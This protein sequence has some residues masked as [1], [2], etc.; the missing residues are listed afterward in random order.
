MPLTPLDISPFFD[1][2]DSTKNYVQVLF[3]PGYPIQSRELTT[4]QS[5]IKDQIEKFGNNIY[6]DGSNIL[7]GGINVG[8]VDVLY[9]SSYT[10]NPPISNT[11]LDES[12]NKI[13]KEIGS[14]NIDQIKKMEGCTVTGLDTGIKAKILKVI[15]TGDVKYPVQLVVTYLKSGKINSAMADREPDMKTTGVNIGDK[16][17]TEGSEVHEFLFGEQIIARFEENYTLISRDY[18]VHFS[19]MAKGA[20]A[21]SSPGVYYFS[22]NFIS[23]GLQSILLAVSTA[24]YPDP[25]ITDPV[26]NYKIGFSLSNRIVTAAEDPSLYD[27]AEGYSSFGTAGASRLQAV[28]TLDKRPILSGTNPDEV[29]EDQNF[30]E[31]VRIVN[32]E[33]LM[34]ISDETQ[35]SRLTETLARR[36][37]DESGD[38][39][40]NPFHIETIDNPDDPSSFDID[41]G[42]SKA[43][44][45][46]FEIE[47]TGKTTLSISKPRDKAAIEKIK[48]LAIDIEVG[49]TIFIDDAY[50]TDSYDY[51]PDRTLLLSFESTTEITSGNLTA[52]ES[53]IIENAGTGT[54]FVS[55]GSPT[56]L[57]GAYFIANQTGAPTWG[58][59]TLKVRNK[60]VGYARVATVGDSSTS[61]KNYIGLSEVTPFYKIIM[62]VDPSLQFGQG[63]CISL[64]NPTSLA[65]SGYGYF[66]YSEPCYSSGSTDHF[67]YLT[68]VTGFL[69]PEYSVSTVNNALLGNQKRDSFFEVGSSLSVM[70]VSTF[71]RLE[72]LEGS[73]S[74]ELMYLAAG[75]SFSGKASDMIYPVG[76]TVKTVLPQDYS[77]AYSVLEKDNSGLFVPVTKS[78]TAP[79][80][81]EFKTSVLTF[82]TYGEAIGGER[83]YVLSLG[84]AGIV[85]SGAGIDLIIHISRSNVGKYTITSVENGGSGFVA[86]DSITISGDSIGGTSP[87]NDIVI[88]LLNPGFSIVDNGAITI[89][90]INDPLQVLV[91]GGIVYQV[92]QT[93]GTSA[94]DITIK[95]GTAPASRAIMGL[96]F[97]VRK[98]HNGEYALESSTTNIDGIGG[99]ISDDGSSP[100]DYVYYDAIDPSDIIL[101]NTTGT[102]TVKPEINVKLYYD[103][104]YELEFVSSGNYDLSN[105][106]NTISSGPLVTGLAYQIVNYV[107]G[108]N[109]SNVGGPAASSVSGTH[110][111]KWFVASGTTPTTWTTSDLLD[112][113]EQSQIKIKGSAFA[114][115]G[116]LDGPHYGSVGSRGNDIVITVNGNASPT[117]TNV[118]LSQDILDNAILF[119][120][121]TYINGDTITIP[122]ILIGGTTGKNDVVIKL[123]VPGSTSPYYD[124]NFLNYF[125]GTGAEYLTNTDLLPE[126]HRVA[127]TTH[128]LETLAITPGPLAYAYGFRADDR[129]IALEVGLLKVLTVLQSITPRMPPTGSK[130]YLKTGSDTSFKVGHKIIGRDSGA[131]AWVYRANS[132]VGL[133]SNKYLYGY[134]Q[135][136]FNGTNGMLWA[137]STSSL[138]IVEIVNKVGDFIRGEVIYQKVYDQETDPTGSI[139]VILERIVS[140]DVDPFYVPTNCVD[141]TNRFIIDTGSRKTISDIG[142]I[143]YRN[144]TTTLAAGKIG[145]LLSYYETTT[146]GDFSAADSY[147]LF[148]VVK[149]VLTEA[150]SDVSGSFSATAETLLPDL[151]NYIDFR[152]I[153]SFINTK[154]R[155]AILTA[156]TAQ[157]YNP[158]SFSTRPLYETTGLPIDE[159]FLY[160]DLE[161]YNGR[162]DKIFLSKKGN[163]VVAKGAPSK[164]PQPAK[165]VDDAMLLYE[166]RIPPYC[167]SVSEI[168]VIANDNRRYTMRD[169]GNIER[170]LNSLQEQVTLNTLEIIALN[171]FIGGTDNPN[172]NRLKIGFLVNG[173][174]DDLKTDITNSENTCVIDINEQRLEPAQIHNSINLKEIVGG[175]GYVVNNGLVT[176]PYTEVNYITQDK[177]SRSIMINNSNASSWIGDLVLSPSRD[178][179]KASGSTATRLLEVDE[180]N[181]NTFNTVN[182]PSSRS[183]WSAPLLT[184][185][186][187]PL[188]NWIGLDKKWGSNV[189]TR[190]NLRTNSVKNEGQTS[191]I[192]SEDKMRG[193]T[194][195]FSGFGLKANVKLS[196]KFNGIDV[197]NYCR[198]FLYNDIEGSLGPVG[199]LYSDDAGQ[200]NGKFALPD[201]T[202]EAGRKLL[203]IGSEDGKTYCQSYYEA[204]GTKNAFSTSIISTRTATNSDASG[205]VWDNITAQSFLVDKDMFVSSVDLYFSK[206]SGIFEERYKTQSELKA[207]LDSYG[208]LTTNTV[209]ATAIKNG[210]G[211]KVVGDL[212][213]ALY[214]SDP[215]TDGRLSL[216]SW[217]SSNTKADRALFASA[218]DFKRF[219]TSKMEET[220]VDGS[221][222]V[223]VELVENSNGY[224]TKNSIPGSSV[225][226]YLADSTK[227]INPNGTN[228]IRPDAS[229]S[230]ISKAIFRHPIYLK[231]GKEYSVCLK[232]ATNKNEVWVAEQGATSSNS[233]TIS[234]NP[235]MG[236]LFTLQNTSTWNIE[237]KLDLKM[238]LNRCNFTTGITANLITANEIRS[239]YV[240]LPPTAL[241]LT[242]GKNLIQ[243]NHNSHNLITTPFLTN[244]LGEN[245]TC[246]IIGV[247][248]TSGETFNGIPISEINGSHTVVH[249]N[250]ASTVNQNFAFS[251]ETESSPI[252]TSRGVTPFL[253]EEAI[254]FNEINLMANVITP[255]GTA[256]T[257]SII[258][259]KFG[260]SIG[261]NAFVGTLEEDGL[262]TIEPIE[263]PI[264]TSFKFNQPR[265]I[266][267][268]TEYNKPSAIVNFEMSSNNSYVSPVIDLEDLQFI[269]TRH[270][271]NYS[272]DQTTIVPANKS[273]EWNTA[274]SRHV[275]VPVVMNNPARSLKFALN[276]KMPATGS[277][278]SLF[279]RTIPFGSSLTL[280]DVPWE[281]ATDI[282][283]ANSTYAE[284]IVEQ[285]TDISTKNRIGNPFTTY[286]VGIV[287]WSKSEA[288]YPIISDFRVIA[289]AT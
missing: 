165:N 54:N 62:G 169:I 122:G 89:K 287:L 31:F 242:S 183:F 228:R 148:D 61:A 275:S 283:R 19:K 249:T 130:L 98:N 57:V 276:F 252:K 265:L 187:F 5:S 236:S 101:T 15:E 33:L 84:Q 23:T 108:D 66:E 69:S 120:G 132:T 76:R 259:K 39:Y 178:F 77:N 181:V 137:D 129:E 281:W 60:P 229:G 106:T 286:Q 111:G 12:G 94:N 4:L 49:S 289:L 280:S 174:T 81:K 203:W 241:Q 140:P 184:P 90:A 172:E 288:N 186:P 2:F 254:Q 279:Y 223:L 114:A 222:A 264:K 233:Q 7:N 211:T 176:L 221:S 128:P 266:P 86:G 167:R 47:K 40:L 235:R 127:I 87:D 133:S 156:G 45:K 26:I 52:G 11:V 208:I 192:S 121:T 25:R 82:D 154:W 202:F 99:F 100:I 152:K 136:Q 134:G 274:I 112:G 219:V 80:K 245:R 119:G 278:I 277:K 164:F 16:N 243:I 96:G 14:T 143:K 220:V 20:M 83:N 205:L 177:K 59:A 30:V 118:P 284:Y 230:T 246:R 37:Y 227:K 56:E 50:E 244:T 200:I 3:R 141:I 161:V 88:Y 210:G 201:R 218:K 196:V 190:I 73:D 63:E 103:G 213:D 170:N 217:W 214:E 44:V 72:I 91:T 263:L 104:H 97:N 199:V 105:T 116:G 43:Y 171:D 256:I 75:T 95:R 179:W 1:D 231:A 125:D 253:S 226:M 123:T 157:N 248:P 151:R 85:T 240:L 251:F 79:T 175:T 51:G 34:D 41:L 58:G 28:L 194:I 21:Y 24:T 160:T 185:D 93:A 144:S 68:N 42:P 193:T 158:F 115:S 29:E 166:L 27:N 237:Q 204:Y 191:V 250:P 145:V 173:F 6:K 267:S 215:A 162:N 113:T 146:P 126:S 212:A 150:V 22:G 107:A 92:Y 131:T 38:Y 147:P 74:G 258:T 232:T 268:K 198:Q 234:P 135:E 138:D 189:D 271:I 207:F 270:L 67:V 102:Q 257:P 261:N 8:T 239:H 285:G 273:S 36:T 272:K 188:V 35:Y 195:S 206:A 209:V 224:P 142:R 110:D 32:N 70:D 225:A 238:R 64:V 216:N 155:D 78:V 153:S 163:F 139:P 262:S 168:D 255:F 65:V 124:A 17:Y 48:N 282:T 46:G 182:S 53:Y 71:N 117:V 55:F 159:T 180:T 13:I 247:T 109:F 197:T 10:L 18:A 269:A 149:P 9:I 260:S